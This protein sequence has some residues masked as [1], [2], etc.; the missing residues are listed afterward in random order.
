MG[1]I[2]DSMSEGGKIPIKQVFQLSS[3]RCIKAEDSK[4]LVFTRHPRNH[5]SFALSTLD[6]C[7]PARDNGD[8]I[9]RP[10]KPERSRQE[11]STP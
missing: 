11:D 7:S 8:L 10:A 6:V 2:K 9:S 1:T 4:L 3:T 5:S